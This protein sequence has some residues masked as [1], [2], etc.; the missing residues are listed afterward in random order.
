MRTGYVRTDEQF[1]DSTGARHYVFRAVSMADAVP[2]GRYDHLPE[3]RRPAEREQINP[4]PKPRPKANGRYQVWAAAEAYYCIDPLGNV[5]DEFEDRDSATQGVMYLN[6][7]R[8]G[9]NY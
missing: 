4:N 9:I 8:L 3:S 2:S 6:S 7:S 5:D 1:T